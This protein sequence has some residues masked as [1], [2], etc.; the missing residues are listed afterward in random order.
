MNYISTKEA[1]HKLPFLLKEISSSHEPIIITDKKANA[2]M[3]SEDDW[4]AIQE[5]LYLLSAPRMR[6]SIKRGLK[7]PLTKCSKKLKW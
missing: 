3:I 5:T 7:T 6:Q 2:V 4:N 1:K